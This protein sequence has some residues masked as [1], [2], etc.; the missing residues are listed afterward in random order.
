MLDENKG[1][2]NTNNQ[3]LS[4]EE[5]NLLNKEIDRATNEHK[6]FTKL[7]CKFSWIVSAVLYGLTMLVSN[8]PKTY[9]LLFW[10]GFG[11]IL[12][13][14]IWAENLLKIGRY[15]KSIKKAIA[16]NNRADLDLILRDIYISL[17]IKERKDIEKA[18]VS[19]NYYKSTI[20]NMNELEK[21]EK[22]L[23]IKLPIFYKHTVLNYPFKKDSF[24]DECL[25]PN[26]VNLVIKNNAGSF[27]KMIMKQDIMPFVIGCDGGEEVYYLN[28]NKETS[29]IFV[30]SCETNRSE[31]KFKSWDE[32]LKNIEKALKEIDEDE[33][34]IQE[35]KK[36][37][38]WWQFW[39]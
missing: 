5:I 7:I 11:L 13:I 21:I 12:C 33:R 29:E 36:N 6:Q 20:M 10:I 34:L 8:V 35:R 32:Y 30:S 1:M 23:K 39:F 4:E 18:V 3:N 9:I 14:W 25:L 37:K 2:N 38:K 28:L 16:T 22:I 27:I 31:V 15:I 24:A 17:A 26:D 19:P